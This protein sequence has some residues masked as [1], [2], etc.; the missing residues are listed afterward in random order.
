[1]ESI[2]Q[3]AGF[4]GAKLEL[5]GYEDEA[6]HS[7]SI[8]M[9]S[10]KLLTPPKHCLNTTLIY[11]KKPPPDEWLELL[12]PTIASFAKQP[13]EVSTL[14]DVDAKEKICIFLDDVQEPVLNQPND[15]EFKALKRIMTD[16]KGVLW[17]S[18][19]GAVE[20]ARPFN[21]LHSGFLRT[22][23]CENP[24]VRYISLDLDP[25]SEFWDT[26]GIT[27]IMNVFRES[28]DYSREQN[29][30]EFEYAVRFG[31]IQISRV[32]EDAQENVAVAEDIEPAPEI[33]PFENGRELRLG[34]DKPGLLDSLTFRDDPTMGQPLPDDWVE[35]KPVA[36]GLNFRDVMVAMGQLNETRMGF[37]CS[38]II[39]RVGKDANLHNFRVGD[40]VYAFTIGYFATTV[41]VP[42][43]SVGHIPNGMSFETAASIPLVFI[44][45]YHALYD[46][47]RLSKGEK[48][49]IH[50]GSGGVG[51]AAIMLAQILGAE[52]FVT[53]GTEEKQ[54]FLMR[55]YGIPPERIFSSRNGRFAEQIMAAT[56]GRGVDVVLNSLAGPLLRETWHCIAT[57]GRFIEIGKRDLEL[58][59]NLDM[60][61]FVRSVS[62]A[63]LD[64]ITLGE[65]RGESVAR[66][67]TE[68]NKLFKDDRIKAVTPVSVY[69]M[70]DVVKAFRTMQAGKHI[71]KIVLK[72]NPGGLVKVIVILTQKRS[73]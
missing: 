27:H 57:F 24:T 18:Q 47:A 38:G 64:L 73:N 42:H 3:R 34:V 58:N 61:P 20:C 71:G 53:V 68:I 37:E 62:F 67:F 33:R 26:S 7:M 44:T 36:F 9:T 1:L 50:S 46:L 14:A 65:Q 22:L 19:G 30:L 72:P 41:R 4:N 69:D 40:A 28:F 10:P 25:A 6:S 70:S 66:I 45:A 39:S 5:R 32:S 60:G 17:I 54:E 15:G 52:L 49:L 55:E 11:V 48:I 29:L 59:N 23:R 16:A 63:S 43:T 12:A 2:F 31:A 21:G 56:N 51:Q 8:F 35:I 13:P